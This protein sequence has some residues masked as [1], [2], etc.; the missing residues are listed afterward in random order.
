MSRVPDLFKQFREWLDDGRDFTT[1]D[2]DVQQVIDELIAEEEALEKGQPTMSQ[3]S[4]GGKP[5]K[6]KKRRMGM[7]SD[8]EDEEEDD[9][10]LI[11]KAN[12]EQ[13]FTLGPWY[14]PNH[15]D[16]H[17]EW[18]DADELQKALWDY[19][20]TGDRQI[21]LQHNKDI[22]AGEWVEAM[23]FP[24]P[25]SLNMTK[26]N[27]EAREVT[28]PTGTVFLGV[29]WLPWAWD[30]VKSNKITGFSIGGS[31]ARVEMAIPVSGIPVGKAAT[32]MVAKQAAEVATE[33]DAMDDLAIFKMVARRYIGGE[34]PIF[35]E[36]RPEATLMRINGVDCVVT[37]LTKSYKSGVRNVAGIAGSDGSRA[38][39]RTDGER[40]WAVGS[41]AFEQIPFAKAQIIFAEVAKK[42]FGSRAEAGRYAANIR[43]QRRGLDAIAQSGGGGSAPRPT[44]PGGIA[45][46]RTY[47]SLSTHCD[48][49][50]LAADMEAAGMNPRSLGSEPPY[51]LLS[52]R[53]TPERRALHEKIIDSHFK[54]PDGTEKTAPDGQPEY[55]FMGGGPASGKSS[56]LESAQEN[57]LAPKW[58]GDGTNRA[59]KGTDR[60]SVAI[61]ADEIKGELPEYRSLVGG[62]ESKGGVGVAGRG[63]QRQAASVVHEESS[64]LSKEVNRRALD[65]GVNVLLDGTG[66]NNPKSMQGKVDNARSA[67]YKVTG[68]YA[69]VPTAV[70]VQRAT[71]RGRPVGQKYTKPDGT[72]GEGQGRYVDPGVVVG[73][74]RGV[75]RVFPEVSKSFD[76]V[77]LFD[78]SGSPPKLIAE[79]TRGKT[80]RVRDRKAYGEFLAKAGE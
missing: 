33:P 28:Y 72:T 48:F 43:W 69:T 6:R 38:V 17:D 78:T 44:T 40:F 65:K 13:M 39:V 24:V 2:S 67:G 42:K 27:G 1:L 79:G 66:D 16:A 35:P 10:N 8:E 32:R 5:A 64:I 59:G 58:A 18:T 71:D 11:Q 25:I 46:E 29:K 52:A 55:I 80:L 20:K 15:N 56:M 50:G 7:Y 21:R 63:G 31:A 12:D 34:E 30:L 76:S 57:G 73:V 26:A 37:P 14:I 77:K 36:P 19:V 3:V 9:D 74:H 49:D 4:Q 61:N 68:I 51:E 75:S 54:N 62:K 70:A 47:G 22:V 60:H 45:L 41:K 23:S 53:L